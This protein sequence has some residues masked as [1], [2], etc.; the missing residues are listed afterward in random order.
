M[1][2]WKSMTTRRKHLYLK[3]AVCAFFTIKI[4]SW[5]LDVNVVFPEISGEI[6]HGM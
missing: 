6:Q 3:A 2:N 1:Y 5:G 4:I